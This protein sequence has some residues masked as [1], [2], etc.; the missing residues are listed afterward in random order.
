METITFRGFSFSLGGPM[1]ASI[2]RLDKDRWEPQYLRIA[3]TLRP[4]E[5]PTEERILE[6]I[7][8]SIEDMKVYK[9]SFQEFEDKYRGRELILYPE[10]SVTPT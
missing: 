8:Q 6:I 5:E 2:E 1:Y 4:E 10:E 7:R 9:Q 3:I